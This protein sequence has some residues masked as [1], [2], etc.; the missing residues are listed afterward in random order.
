MKWMRKNM[1]PL[2]LPGRNLL[3]SKISFRCFALF[4]KKWLKIIGEKLDRTFLKRWRT[5]WK[6]PW[7][8]DKN[9]LTNLSMCLDTFTCASRRV[10]ASFS[11]EKYNTE[12]AMSGFW[13]II[14]GRGSKVK[15]CFLCSLD[16]C[17]IN[18]TKE[19]LLLYENRRLVVTFSMVV[20]S[21][22]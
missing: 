7:C 18:S 16:F 2:F 4:S 11:I 22:K 12:N 1:H 9:S 13:G 5:F 20:A 6:S 15:Y 21:N 3:S 8:F 17:N 14:L 19:C 10:F